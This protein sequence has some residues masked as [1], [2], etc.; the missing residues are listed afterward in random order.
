M[1]DMDSYKVNERAWMLIFERIDELL[2]QG[3]KQSEIARILSCDRA[4]IHR[5]LADK[6][7][8]DRTSFR[9]MLRYLDRLRIPMAEVFSEN[10]DGLPA[11]S[12]DR[13]PTPFDAAIASTLLDVATALGKGD[14]EIAR[15]SSTLTASDVRTLL[16]GYEPMRASD[17]ACICGALGIAPEQILARA[18]ALS[19]DEEG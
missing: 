5:W 10:P 4:T 12:P 18:S 15:G 8:G 16:T 11:P 2:R 3:K 19:R 7:G 9:D 13:M 6:R 14:G 17:F 1:A